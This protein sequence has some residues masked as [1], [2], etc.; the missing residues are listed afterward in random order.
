MQ[1]D[2]RTDGPQE[3]RQPE[4][5]AGGARARKKPGPRPGKKRDTQCGAR[6]QGDDWL[7]RARED[8]AR[9]YGEGAHIIS[10]H[11]GGAWK[12][13][14]KPG[15]GGAPDEGT[16][17]KKTT[18]TRA[19]APVA[20]PARAHKGGRGKGIDWDA[21]ENLPRLKTESVK[22]LAEAFGVS[23][24]AVYHAR[25]VRGIRNTNATCDVRDVRDVFHRV[26]TIFFESSREVELLDELVATG[27]YG[28]TRGSVAQAV[29]VER[30]RAIALAKR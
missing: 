30:L 17:V 3:E 18:K 10:E 12:D 19:A 27:I 26:L 7:A 11:D 4:A 9:L 2:T 8:L 29:L 13:G 22:V 20:P 23:E 5:P 21:P 6:W 1:K 14:K 25:K 16:L 24:Q 15:A 28:D